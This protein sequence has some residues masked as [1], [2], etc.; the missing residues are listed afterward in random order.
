MGI[1]YRAPFQSLADRIDQF[2]ENGERCRDQFASIKENFDFD[3]MICDSRFSG[4]P[5]VKIEMG[6]P[7]LS[8]GLH[9][10]FEYNYIGCKVQNMTAIY[11]SLQQRFKQLCTNLF[12]NMAAMLRLSK[13]C[14]KFDLKGASLGLDEMLQQNSSVSMQLGTPAFE[15]GRHRLV[16]SVPFIGALL[17]AF[18][19]SDEPVWSNFR[20]KHYKKIA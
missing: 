6:R 2:I 19:P 8:I 16:P 12:G 1:P 17:P 18:E 3:F 7:V 20:L 15:Y 11:S 14:E 13:M 10:R 5:F 4:I 9:P